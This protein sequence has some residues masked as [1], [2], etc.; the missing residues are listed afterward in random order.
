MINWVHQQ[1][2]ANKQQL[3][4]MIPSHNTLISD[5]DLL[6]FALSRFW[7]QIFSTHKITDFLTS[8][9]GIIPIL[10]SVHTD[11]FGECDLCSP[12]GTQQSRLWHEFC[13]KTLRYYPKNPLDEFPQQIDDEWWK[14][15]NQKTLMRTMMLMVETYEAKKHSHDNWWWLWW[16]WELRKQKSFWWRWGL[17]ISTEKQ[18]QLP[19]AATAVVNLKR[20]QFCA[21]E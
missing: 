1:L 19:A 16:L 6:S 9:W 20:L 2:A 5:A 15:L 10:Q 7:L 13:N 11:V 17:L 3:L 4:I 21:H 8:A 14:L 18:K 12:G